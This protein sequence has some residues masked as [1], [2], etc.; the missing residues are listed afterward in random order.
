MP[1]KRVE[2]PAN[3]EL[4]RVFCC[5]SLFLCLFVL[6]EGLQVPAN[7]ELVRVFC[8]FSPFLCLF[9]LF[10]GV[11][12]P[13][14]EELARV[15]GCFYPF[16][17]LYV[18]LEGLQVPANEDIARVFCRFSPF[19]C[20]F[21]LLGGMQVPA[22][23]DI[24][25]VSSRAYARLT[26]KQ[27]NKRTNKQ[28]N[29]QTNKQTNENT[30][31]GVIEKID[32]KDE[33]DG[34][35]FGRYF[36]SRFWLTQKYCFRSSMLERA[37]FLFEYSSL[38]ILFFTLRKKSQLFSLGICL[39]RIYFVT[40]RHEKPFSPFLPVNREPMRESSSLEYDIKTNYE[41]EKIYSLP[42][43]PNRSLDRYGTNRH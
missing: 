28:T 1:L 9:V 41:N 14:N 18:L 21:V 30:P 40:L 3:E 5:F 37:S 4:A 36:R 27:T 39:L 7:E 33:D 16:L 13:E 12:V 25:H 42:I 6:L 2:Y 19:L 11:Q 20:L 23:E 15:F 24:A 29:E 26:N 34:K 35:N 22:N 10:E 32:R 8:C 17:C 38:L 31:N 43:I